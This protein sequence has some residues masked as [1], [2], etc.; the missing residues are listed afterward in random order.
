MLKDLEGIDGMRELHAAL[1]GVFEVN[2][3]S[4]VA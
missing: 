4:G 3:T 1:C 2:V